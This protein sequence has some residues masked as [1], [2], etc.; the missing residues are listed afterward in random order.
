LA[1][2]SFDFIPENPFRAGYPICIFIEVNHFMGFTGLGNFAHLADADGIVPK[3]TF[4]PVPLLTLIENGCPGAGNQM[5]TLPLIRTRC[6]HQAGR[7]DVIRL[8]QPDL[9]QG[10]MRARSQPIH[11]YLEP[12][13]QGTFPGN[14]LQ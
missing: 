2:I 3:L 12:R 4:D 14:M 1:S 6:A 5:H 10:D 9:G 13:V 7:T 11:D 8:D